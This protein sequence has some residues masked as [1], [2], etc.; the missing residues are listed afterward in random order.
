MDLRL[1]A[2]RFVRGFR[3]TRPRSGQHVRGAARQPGPPPLHSIS[4][5]HPGSAS[6]CLRGWLTRQANNGS[7]NARRDVCRRHALIGQPFRALSCP[8]GSQIPTHCAP[9][10]GSALGRSRGGG[11]WR[12]RDQPETRRP[13]R[14]LHENDRRLRRRPRQKRLSPD[15]GAFRPANASAWYR[16]LSYT[17]DSC[18]G[19]TNPRNQLGGPGDARPSKLLEDAELSPRYPRRSPL[20]GGAALWAYFVSAVV[21]YWTASTVTN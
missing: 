5:A 1:V 16:A 9:I 3:A 18:Q 7:A 12:P 17:S 21:I 19:A 14:L 20:A 2:A 4:V 10:G 13:S 6:F 8:V 15:K 11:R